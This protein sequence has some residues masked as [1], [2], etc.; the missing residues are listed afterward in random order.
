M[1]LKH[2]LLFKYMFDIEISASSAV[3]LSTQLTSLPRILAACQQWPEE[4]K[5]YSNSTEIWLL[6]DLCAK[7]RWLV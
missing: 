6:E 2:N 7:S 4:A 1:Q 5:R 3:R